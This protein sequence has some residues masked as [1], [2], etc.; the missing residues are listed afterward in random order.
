MY[1][2]GEKFEKVI[3]DEMD[4]FICSK[5]YSCEMSI[6]FENESGVKRVFLWW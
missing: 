4:I 3:D 1:S 5:Y 2:V 6:W